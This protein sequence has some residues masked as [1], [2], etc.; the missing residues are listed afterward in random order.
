MT[1]KVFK[2]C[3]QTAVLS[4]RLLPSCRIVKPSNR[5]HIPIVVALLRWRITSVALYTR[6][7][8][9]GYLF[10]LNNSIITSTFS[11]DDLRLCC[12]T[13]RL[14]TECTVMHA[15]LLVPDFLAVRPVTFMDEHEYDEEWKVEEAVHGTWRSYK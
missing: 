8:C 6:A 10:T 5:C 11:N 1:V 9:R 15:G 14:D 3:T 13:M 12:K 7:S 4:D 2:T